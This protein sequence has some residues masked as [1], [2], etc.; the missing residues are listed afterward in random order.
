PRA[1]KRRFWLV[2]LLSLGGLAVACGSSSSAPSG[3]QGGTDAADETTNGGD[4]TGA[5]DDVA[6]ADNPY[7]DGPYGTKV[8]DVLGDVQLVGYMH[9]D[10][11]TVAST[12]DYLP[13]S[14]ADVRK[15]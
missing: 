11:T 9:F 4:D 14:L 6:E 7:P 2:C 13:T 8:G 12:V 5:T 1:M 3:D 15:T 10:P